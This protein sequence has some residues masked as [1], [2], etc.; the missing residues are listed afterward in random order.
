MRLAGK[1]AIVTGAAQGIGKAYVERFLQEGAN[2]AVA[3]IND[4]LGKQTA[5]D[6]A[7][8]GEVMFIHADVSDAESA[9]ELASQVHRA[10]GRID[11]LV[12]NAAIYYGIDFSDRSF[13]YLQKVMAV[14]MFGPWTVSR[15]VAPYMVKQGKGKI[16]HQS[17][18]AAF[19]YA[20]LDIQYPTPDD[21]EFE[22]PTF[23][24]SWS[25]WGLVGLTRFMAAVLG[26]KGINVNC[27]CPGVTNTEATRVGAEALGGGFTDL[28]VQFSALRK[29]LEP[30]DLCGAAVFF[31][32]DDSDL[33]TGQTLSVDAGMHMG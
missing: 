28:L 25:K 14:N 5:D 21:D 22:L 13:E 30:G 31:A 27:I 6:L 24:Y 26:P 3:D 32:S 18:D 12:N 1:T 2:V 29:Q 33:I 4:D 11:V 10:W 8:L 19:L 15:A 7:A 20:G 9:R 16:I 17:S 23:H